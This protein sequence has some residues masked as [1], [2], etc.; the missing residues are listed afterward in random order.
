MTR[1]GMDGEDFGELAELI[2]DVIEHRA[3]VK[4]RVAEFRK[5]FQ[6]MQYCFSG[7]ELEERLQI[8]HRMV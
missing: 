1:F 7:E 3:T 2:R 5:R 8:L 4:P 6:E